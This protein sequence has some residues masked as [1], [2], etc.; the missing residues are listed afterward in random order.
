MSTKPELLVLVYEWPN[1]TILT[2]RQRKA[3]NCFF[4][5]PF[6]IYSYYTTLVITIH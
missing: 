3:L 1:L 5:L 2:P 6:D 4:E